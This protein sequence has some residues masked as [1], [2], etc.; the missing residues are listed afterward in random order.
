MRLKESFEEIKHDGVKGI[1]I[2]QAESVHIESPLKAVDMSRP[3]N[4]SQ[5]S[6]KTEEARG[7]EEIKEEYYEFE[8]PGIEDPQANRNEDYSA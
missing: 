8:M 1:L 5:I 4:M 2:P 7:K 3:V 6:Q